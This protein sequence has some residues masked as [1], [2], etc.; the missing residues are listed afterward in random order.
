[1]SAPRLI[2][3]AV[4]LRRRPKRAREERSMAAAMVTSTSASFGTGL[5]VAS[6][7]SR[8]IRSTPGDDLAARTKASTA[9]SRWRRGSGTEGCGLSCRL[10]E[11]CFMG[12][13][14]DRRLRLNVGSEGGPFL[15]YDLTA[16]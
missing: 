4:P 9:L 12:R 14:D 7:P 6:E 16:I 2:V 8:A 5:S 3:C 1:M 15:V 10:F 13:Y 11:S